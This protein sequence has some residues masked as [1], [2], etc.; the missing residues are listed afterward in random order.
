MSVY[1][2][3]L[4]VFTQ[5]DTQVHVLQQQYAFAAMPALKQVHKLNCGPAFRIRQGAEHHCKVFMP[6]DHDGVTS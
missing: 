3:Q 6:L 4:Q 1:V 5:E 2:T